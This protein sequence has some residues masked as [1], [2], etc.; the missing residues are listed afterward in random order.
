MQVSTNTGYQIEYQVNSTSGS[1]TRISSGGTIG[2]LNHNDNVYARLT[3]GNNVTLDRVF[4]IK[5]TVKPTISINGT[6]ITSN[7][8]KVTVSASDGQSGLATS[9]TYK[10]Y[11][12][13]GLKT[14]STSNSYTFTGL[15]GSTPYTIKVEAVDKANNVGTV[16]EVIQQKQ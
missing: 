12:N 15:S 5:D 16:S 10:Y 7:S 3:D 9:G 14:T 2:N 4:A 13:N 8:I 11:L 1:W 6:T